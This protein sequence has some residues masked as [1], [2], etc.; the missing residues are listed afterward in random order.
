MPDNCRSPFSSTFGMVVYVHNVSNSISEETNGIQIAPGSETNIAVDRTF[1]VR[2]PSPYSDCVQNNISASAP[3]DIARNTFIINNGTY[4]QQVCLQLCEQNFLV[5]NFK[6]YD[7]RLPF[8][9][10]NK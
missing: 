3:N 6:C 5:Q 1:L 8:I 9:N 7:E 2:K 10:D 4:S